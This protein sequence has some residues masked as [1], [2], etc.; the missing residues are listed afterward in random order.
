MTPG[1]LRGWISRFS[2]CENLRDYGP[3]GS[4]K[5]V[6][7]KHLIGLEEPAAGEILIEGQPIQ[8]PEVMSQYRMAMV[9]NPGAAQFANCRG[10]RGTYLAEHRLQPPEVIARI[11]AEKLEEVGL[12]GTEEKDA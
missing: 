12:K 1:S 8:S 11:V 6:L 9:F 7:L 2:R 3:S 10:K 4:G 5:T